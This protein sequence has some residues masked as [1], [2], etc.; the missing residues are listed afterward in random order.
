VQ[1]AGVEQA[2]RRLSVTA[3]LGPGYDATRIRARSADTADA[4]DAAG[5][6]P[7]SNPPSHHKL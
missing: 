3:T 5:S 7:R 6:A 2:V 1:L 4:G